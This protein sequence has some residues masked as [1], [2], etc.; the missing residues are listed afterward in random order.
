MSFD[1]VTDLKS[2]SF[3]AIKVFKTNVTRS[4][5]NGKGSNRKKYEHIY[6]VIAQI[7]SS[8]CNFFGTISSALFL[9]I[10]NFIRYAN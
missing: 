1:Y 10:L 5:G 4:Q 2:R 3:D 6:W 8:Q 7:A 9:S